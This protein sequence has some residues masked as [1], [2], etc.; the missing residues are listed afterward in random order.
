MKSKLRESVS[1]SR[2]WLTLALYVYFDACLSHDD[3]RRS[4]DN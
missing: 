4:P 1:D 3:T 2:G